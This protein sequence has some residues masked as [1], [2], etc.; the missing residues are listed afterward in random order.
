MN[1][2]VFRSFSK[3][4][5]NISK[6]FLRPANISHLSFVN[7][8]DADRK[9]AKEMTEK[10]LEKI[11]NEAYRAVYWTAMQIL[12]N[13]ADAEDVVQDTFVSFIESYGNL[14]DIEYTD[15]VSIEESN[16]TPELVHHLHEQGIEVFCW[17]VDL[18]D[19][20]QYLVSCDVDVIGTDNPLLISSAVDRADYSGGLPRV[21]HIVM[22]IVA[23]MDK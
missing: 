19:T 10:E 5:K 9:E 3:S 14:E 8:I 6:I 1:N 12:K 15:N 13:E 17:T 16:V 2:R 22:H 4:S 18:D 7:R 20:V 21:F 11:Y 23:G